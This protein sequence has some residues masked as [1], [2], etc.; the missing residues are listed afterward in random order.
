MSWHSTPYLGPLLIA[1][2]MSGGLALLVAGRRRSA[3][4]A[5]PFVVLTL[6]VAGWSL[7]YAL[8]MLSANLASAVFW[9]KQ[10]YLGIVILPLTWLLFA[11]EYTGRKRWLTRQRIGLLLIEPI[12]IVALV[13][14]NERHHL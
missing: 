2:L 11:L 8:E 3:P 13:E 7:G 10:E 6:A 4:G 12:A 5:L 14:T 1:A 9:A